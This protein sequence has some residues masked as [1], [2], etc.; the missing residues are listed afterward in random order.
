MNFIFIILVSFSRLVLASDGCKCDNLNPAYT[1][2]AHEPDAKM[3]TVHNFAV[4]LVLFKAA[5]AQFPKILPQEDSFETTQKCQFLK[6]IHLVSRL[7]SEGL[8][9]PSLLQKTLQAIQLH[10]NVVT[11]FPHPVINLFATL[12]AMQMSIF[13]PKELHS[14]HPRHIPQMAGL[15]GTDTWTSDWQ[16]FETDE[17][18]CL[19]SHLPS[20]VLMFADWILFMLPPCA[21]DNPRQRLPMLLRLVYEE[22]GDRVER[23]YELR[24]AVLVSKLRDVTMVLRINTERKWSFVYPLEECSRRAQ[25]VGAKL[26]LHGMISFEIPCALFR[27]PSNPGKTLVTRKH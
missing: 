18:V 12:A 17:L 10:I 8:Y 21:A 7:I 16:L 20:P 6:K 25:Y 19:Q 11:Q 24:M 5:F 27:K 1:I 2:K 9:N 4:A 15:D 26:A 13:S 3:Q 23:E 22:D 14:V